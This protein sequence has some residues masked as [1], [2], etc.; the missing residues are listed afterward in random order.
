MVAKK[1]HHLKN[2]IVHETNGIYFNTYDQAYI[3]I[4]EMKMRNVSTRK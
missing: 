4:W 2:T 1:E 3:Y